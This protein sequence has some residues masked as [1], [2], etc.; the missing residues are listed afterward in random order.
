MEARDRTS[1]KSLA[2]D[3]I[4]EHGSRSERRKPRFWYR[5]V[6]FWFVAAALAVCWLLLRSFVFGTVYVSSDSML[7]A[8]QAGDCIF[9]SKLAYNAARLPR[10]GDLVAVRLPAAAANGAARAVRRVAAVPGDEV[11]ISGGEVRI[12]NGA[13]DEQPPNKSVSAPERKDAAVFRLK[14]NEYFL[15]NDYRQSAGDSRELGPVCA[16]EI[17]GRAVFVYWAWAADGPVLKPDLSRLGRVL[18]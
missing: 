12:I 13:E 8:V 10:R 6:S 18:R 4:Y 16:D 15:L 14:T 3:E 5:S 17:I 2:G 1:V 11:R 7:P 9:V